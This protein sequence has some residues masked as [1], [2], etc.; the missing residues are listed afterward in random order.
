ML[1][2]DDTFMI[3]AC[4][5]LWAVLSSQQA[6]DFVQSRL[7]SSVTSSLE[8]TAQAL[9]D[10]ALQVPTVHALFNVGSAT[11]MIGSARVTFTQQRI[12]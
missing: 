6:V 7:T 4:N 12:A 8:D 1:G 10:H 9:V 11:T 2:R 5:S 3:I